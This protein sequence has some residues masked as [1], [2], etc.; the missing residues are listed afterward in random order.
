[1]TKLCPNAGLN[2]KL[3]SRR[4][5]CSV[6]LPF[7]SS[8]IHLS[9]YYHHTNMYLW[10]S[11]CALPFSRLGASRVFARTRKGEGVEYRCGREGDGTKRKDCA[12]AV[13]ERSPSFPF[14]SAF[15]L[16]CTVSYTG[17]LLNKNAPVSSPSPPI[18]RRA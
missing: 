4:T 2:Q 14:S 16:R 7:L 5:P 8:N 9:L 17:C 1:M 15:R 12:L 18:F 6:I 10:L 3:F 13:K 11:A